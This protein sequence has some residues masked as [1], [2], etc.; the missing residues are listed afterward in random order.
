MVLGLVIGLARDC[1]VEDV[2]GVKLMTGFE[3]QIDQV[4]LDWTVWG[5]DT[6]IATANAPA[7]LPVAANS[8]D[9]KVNLSISSLPIMPSKWP[10]IC[11]FLFF[12]APN[13]L[14]A[15]LVFPVTTMSGFISPGSKR[16]D[17]SLR[18][19]SSTED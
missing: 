14:V 4:E 6:P 19:G 2:L 11:S 1:D 16:F 5:L 9:C 17:D 12:R 13:D 10:L 18:S 7:L 3:V 8:L 15:R